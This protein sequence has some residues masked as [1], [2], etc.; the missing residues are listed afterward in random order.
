MGGR[1]DDLPGASSEQEDKDGIFGD[2]RNAMGPAKY[3]PVFIHSFI[4]SFDE[5]FLNLILGQPP[6]DV[7]LRHK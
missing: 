2:L 5:H 3:A 6:Q 7:Q 4:H 1:K